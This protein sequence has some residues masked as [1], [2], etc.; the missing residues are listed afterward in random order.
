MLVRIEQAADLN[1]KGA[2][3]TTAHDSTSFKA[4]FLP[5]ALRFMIYCKHDGLPLNQVNL[6]E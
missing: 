2:V 4:T 6:S 3:I 1:W 5:C